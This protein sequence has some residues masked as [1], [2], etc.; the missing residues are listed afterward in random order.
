MTHIEPMTCEEF[1]KF[2]LTLR[3]GDE[4][5]FG[6]DTRVDYPNEIPEPNDVECWYFARVMEIN[7]YCSRFI[8]LDYAGG[9]EA[10]AI[11]LNSDYDWCDGDDETIVPSYV[12]M[13]FNNHRMIAGETDVVFVE[14]EDYL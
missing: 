4:I 11:P 14:V 5:T 9:E 3:T 12:K 1:A 13:Y 8:L 2:L 7:E 6:C 10:F